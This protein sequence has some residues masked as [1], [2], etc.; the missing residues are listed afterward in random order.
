M[1]VDLYLKL[2][3][4]ILKYYRGHTLSSNL[5]QD[6]INVMIPICQKIEK[7]EYDMKKD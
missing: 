7:G 2:S 1:P 5:C 4:V 3:N 6:F